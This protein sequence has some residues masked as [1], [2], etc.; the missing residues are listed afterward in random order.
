MKPLQLGCLVI[1]ACFLSALP[2]QVAG[3]DANAQIAAA[4]R[5]VQHAESRLRLYNLVEYPRQLRTL[6]REIRLAKALLESA[7]RR[8]REYEQF[9]KFRY[10]KPL[11][12]S[13]ENARLLEL[14]TRLR[15]E[16]LQDER[17]HLWR[18]RSARQFELQTE[19]DFAKRQLSQLLIAR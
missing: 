4:R 6:D 5:A 17:L 12:V 13:L 14:E 7:R 8:V 18:T 11:F 10:S 16:A 15:V 2:S 1:A 19:L 9:D 3:Q